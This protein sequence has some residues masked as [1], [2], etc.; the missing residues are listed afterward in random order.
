MQLNLVSYNIHGLND[1]ATLGALQHYIQG[2]QPKVDI[3][4]LQEHKLKNLQ[5][6]QLGRRLWRGA[7]TWCLDATIG[8][9]NAP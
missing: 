3:L 5:D 8:Y 7:L 9:N 1:Q 6:Q 2:L 4:M